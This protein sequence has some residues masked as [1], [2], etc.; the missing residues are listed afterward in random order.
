MSVVLESEG[1]KRQLVTKGA[2]EEILSICSLVEY[3]GKVIELTDE[4]KE[5]V[6]NRVAGLNED[7]MR[8]IG[9]A[10]K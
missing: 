2:V 9:L 1:N 10:Q 6:I 7:G 4:I 5:E 3:E 8:I